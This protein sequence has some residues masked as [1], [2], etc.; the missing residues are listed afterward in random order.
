M[1]SGM[2]TKYKR[3]NFIQVQDYSIT[4][5]EFITKNRSSTRSFEY[6]TM[7]VQNPL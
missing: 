1:K 2:Q 5:L 7:Q 4:K 3:E 6:K